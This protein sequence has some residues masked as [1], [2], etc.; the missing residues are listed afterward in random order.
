MRITEDIIERWYSQVRVYPDDPHWYWEGRRFRTPRGIWYGQMQVNGRTELAHRVSFTIHKGPIP[1][2]HYVCHACDYGLC[3]CPDCLWAGIPQEN[4]DDK[5]AKG[6][7]RN[8]YTGRLHI[9][10]T[11]PY[12]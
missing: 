7:H 8:G 4:S 3:V 10:P 2:G 6:R 1:E 9:P 5:I 11:G 12:C